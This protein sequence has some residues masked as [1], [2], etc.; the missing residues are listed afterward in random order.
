MLE[1]KTITGV[2]IAMRRDHV[3]S[4]QQHRGDTSCTVT[5]S[6]GDRHEIPVAYKDM[7]A[8]VSHSTQQTIEPY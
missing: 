6:T 3:I 2:N 8:L 7:L 5:L 1:V 4:I